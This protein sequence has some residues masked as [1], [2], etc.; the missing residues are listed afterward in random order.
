MQFIH[1]EDSNLLG[2]VYQFP[3][4]PLVTGFQSPQLPAYCVIT[5]KNLSTSFSNFTSGYHCLPPGYQV[6]N[7]VGHLLSSM[8]T[9]CSYHFNRL[10]SI[11]PNIVTPTFSLSASFLTFSSLE[12]P[13]ALLQKSISVLSFSLTF[14]P[15]SKFPKP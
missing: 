8:C 6:I 2:Y 1:P 5:L 13:A 7:H 15:V 12:V 14:N 9:M 11:S 10:F 3:S 4:G